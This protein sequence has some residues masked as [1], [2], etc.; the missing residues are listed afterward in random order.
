MS[1]TLLSVS[2]LERST[3]KSA[4]IAAILD[5][6]WLGHNREQSEGTMRPIFDEREAFPSLFE[7]ASNLL[8]RTPRGLATA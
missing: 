5:L 2:T 3:A 8:L 1:C 7:C 4:S 6:S